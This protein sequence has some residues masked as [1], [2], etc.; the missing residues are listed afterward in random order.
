MKIRKRKS[1]IGERVKK[2]RNYLK[3]KQSDFC[4][5]VG[6]SAP[7]LSDIENNKYNPGYEF[8]MNIV[9]KYQVNLYWL[10]FDK[11]PMFLDPMDFDKGMMN[12]EELNSEEREFFRYFK[13]SPLFKHYILL[14]AREYLLDRM[15]KIEKDIVNKKNSGNF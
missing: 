4:K 13:E 2:V 5:G 9:E 12:L 3:I 10:L 14:S 11:G 7:S 6:I 15:D 8:F 1:C